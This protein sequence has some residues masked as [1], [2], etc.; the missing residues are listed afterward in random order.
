MASSATGL[1]FTH[2]LIRDTL[3]DELDPEDRADAHL[4]AAVALAARSD[5]VPAVIAQ[6]L[7]D[8]GDR[9]DP[10]EV[11]RWAGEAAAARRISG[12]REAARWSEEAA[13][14]WGRAGD[15]DQQGSLL[16]SAII[17]WSTVGD[18]RRAL[19]LSEALSH[20]DLGR[21]P[22]LRADLLGGLASLLGFPS[23]DG[24]RR[25]VSGARSAIV[26]LA[27]RAASGDVR[28]R[29]RLAEARLNV[30]RGPLHH[31]DRIGWLAE[32]E[33]L[34]PAG[35][36]VLGRIQHLYWAT[37]LAFESGDL[38]EVERSVREW[39][40]LADRSDSAFWT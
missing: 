25:D 36:N 37:S 24:F 35:S 31:E 2:A 15:T 13:R 20:P 19:R 11:A 14:G 10:R 17:G 18:S 7:V 32:Y 23:V 16:A 33:R 39:E 28:S 5:A 6:H 12:H 34:L 27:D 38:H 21:E 26:E 8:A 9:S 1:T 3:D 40:L 22:D 30:E 29:G 4:A